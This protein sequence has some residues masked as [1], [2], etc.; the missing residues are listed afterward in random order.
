MSNLRIILCTPGLSVAALVMMFM[1]AFSGSIFP[2]QSVIGLEEV[3]LSEAAFAALMVLASAS[4]VIAAVV[5]GIL[6]DRFANRRIFAIATSACGTL[7][8]GLMLVAPRPV[9]FIICHGIAVPI[10]ISLM[11]QVFALGRLALSDRPDRRVIIL[12]WIRACMS[13]AYLAALL[14]WNW[15]FKGGGMLMGVYIGAFAVSLCMT[16]T[17]LLGWPRHGRTKWADAP[18]GLNFRQALTEILRG[19]IVIRLLFMGAMNSVIS[20]F[21]ALLPL[22]FLATPNRTAGDT[23]LY[24]G[25]VAG[26]EVPVMLT[27][28]L[29]GRR[30]SRSMLIA[31][32]GMLYALNI[33]ALQIMAASPLVWGLSFVG[34]ASGAVFMGLQIS[35]L[36]DLLN[37]RPGTAGALLALQKL[38][39]DLAAA[40][41]F[42]LGTTLGGFGTAA[43]IGGAIGCIGSI[44]LL[45]ADRRTEPIALAGA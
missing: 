42:L 41:A 5:L 25:L 30:F 35:Y 33:I 1:G 26:W 7:G 45:I 39:G 2:F 14:V 40:V 21:M 9:S 17:L 10:T 27:M 28:H 34:G 32:G 36:Q 12:S 4:G 38:I 24:F 20:L 18:S 8:L 43:L 3:G 23:A 16:V 11:G 44:G 29:W 37:G 13:G 31:L 22:I 6:S 19:A 15:Y